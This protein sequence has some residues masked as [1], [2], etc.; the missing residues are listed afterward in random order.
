MCVYLSTVYLSIFI[1]F[2]S[3]YPPHLPYEDAIVAEHGLVQ[4]HEAA[5]KWKL[6]SCSHAKSWVN[7]L[8]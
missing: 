8:T 1:T 6:M 4:R 7:L 5:L 3:V 2:L